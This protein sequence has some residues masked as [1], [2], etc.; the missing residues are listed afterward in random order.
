MKVCPACK[1]QYQD[2]QSFCPIDGDVLEND[3]TTLVGATLD[4]QYHI[5]NLLGKGGMGAVYKARHIL[6]GDRVA[7]KVL[8]PEMRNNAEWLRRF[9][10]EGQAARR[11]RHPNAV[12]VYDLR[13]TNEG[14]IYMVMEYVEGKTLDAELR[15]RHRFT[16]PDALAVLEPVMSVLNAAHEQGV[17]HRDLKPENI[18]IGKPSTGGA[19]TVKLLDL[20]IAKISELAGTPSTETNAPLTVV[21]QILGT[22]YYMSPEQWGEVARDRTG[23]VDGRADIY[24]LGVVFYELI[25]G[26][27]PFNGLS[28]AEIRKE[29]VSKV[30]PPLNQ[31]V[32]EVPAGFAEAIAQAMAKDRA[33]RPATA[34][35]L[36]NK[37]RQALGM[38]VLS[39]ASFNLSGT[40]HEGAAPS[41]TTNADLDLASST[42][43]SSGGAAVPTNYGAGV[44]TNAPGG[45]GSGTEATVVSYDPNLAGGGARETGI[46][47]APPSPSPSPLAATSMAQMPVAPVEPARP[48]PMPTMMSSP[49][50]LAA[51]AASAIPAPGIAPY[52][53]APPKKGKAGVFLGVGGVVV[54]LAVIVLGVGA[55]LGYKYWYAVPEDKVAFNYWLETTT[56]ITLPGKRMAQE[57]PELKSG[58]SFRFHIVPQSDGYLYV[59]GQDAAGKQT[60]YLTNQPL[61]ET[62]VTTNE[63]KSGQEY[64]FPRQIWLTLDQNK[65]TERYTIIFSPKKLDAPG[66]LVDPAAKDLNP[67]QTNELKAFVEKYSANK[68]TATVITENG[69]D[70]FITLKIPTAT[71]ADS[72]VVYEMKLQH[73]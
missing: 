39:A 5:E 23:E 4:G 16:A 9:R 68:P 52:P 63:A 43:G 60:T 15:S 46:G 56:D 35:E 19:P 54:V 31:V 40:S 11:F 28:L 55:F 41:S 20:G 45:P 32:P 65:G 66:F 1:T 21:G 73:Q 34:A 70:P 49:Q 30:A 59:I 24:S 27:R 2:D 58:E 36:A 62:G 48:A 12:T 29:H 64:A 6:L 8:P 25:S 3:P 13:T 18:M 14:M 7:I 22:P 26:R 33:D 10:R 37:L 17:V 67:D 44:A 42:G 47:N 53:A 61:A 71:E 51:P 50:V 72:P 57:L 69:A 38:P